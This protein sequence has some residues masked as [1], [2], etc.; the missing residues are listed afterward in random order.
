[1]GVS[2]PTLLKRRRERRE[3]SKCLSWQHPVGFAAALV[4]VEVA[5]NPH[6]SLTG[7]VRDV[8]AA[9]WLSAES[10]QHLLSRKN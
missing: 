6:E 2:I 8:L 7:M 4:R 9:S 1:M 5:A 3:E 10:P